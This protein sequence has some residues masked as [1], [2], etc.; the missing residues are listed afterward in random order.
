MGDRKSILIIG[1]AGGAG[2][3]AIQLAKHFGAFPI[4]ATA[5]RPD[6]IAFC[7]SLGAD[8]V[9]SHGNFKEDLANITDLNNGLVDNV[10]VSAEDSAMADKVVDVT[11][12]MGCICPIVAFHPSEAAFTKMYLN[13]V[14]LSFGMMFCRSLHGLQPEK[15][16]DLLAHVAKMIDAGNIRPIVGKG[17]AFVGGINA[18]NLKKAMTLQESGKAIGKIVVC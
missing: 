1:G 2:S 14:T 15:Q 9:I 16:G 8:Y 12:P 3:F 18:D 6:S 17:Q 10:Y 11:A 13:R 4:I 5:S 7:K